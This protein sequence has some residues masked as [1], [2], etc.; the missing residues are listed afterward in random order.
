[1][2]RKMRSRVGSPS[3]RNASVNASIDTCRY[4]DA[5][6]EIN[7]LNPFQPFRHVTART[8][9]VRTITRAQRGDGDAQ[10]LVLREVGGV[11]A[12]LVRRLGER[13]QADDLLHDVFAHLLEVLPKFDPNGPA[14]LTSWAFTVA[15]RWLLMQRRK[16]PLQLVPLDGALGVA[17]ESVDALQTV[18][19]N[20][21]A[22]LLDVE[23][24]ALPEEQKRA[25][26]LTQLRGMSLEEAARA[27]GVPLPT[28]KTR[29]HRA[30]ATLVLRLGPALDRPAARGGAHAVR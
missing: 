26:T 20:E 12:S 5:P 6:P 30:R 23:L 7:S 14:Q 16:R 29:L 27:E 2:S 9:E 18:A 4:I 25:F 22:L 1:M 28:L 11:V 3:A 21:L 13:S 10:A 15:Q 8:M 17:D 19:E 24:R